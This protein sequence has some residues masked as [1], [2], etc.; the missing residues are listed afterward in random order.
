MFAVEKDGISIP[1][2]IRIGPV[3][4]RTGPKIP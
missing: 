3:F 1:M 2:S 4:I